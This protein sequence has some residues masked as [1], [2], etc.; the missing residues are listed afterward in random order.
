LETEKE[1]MKYNNPE[2]GNRM[3][4]LQKVIAFLRKIGVLK[5]GGEVRT[6]KSSKDEGYKPPDPLEN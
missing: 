1:Q 5:V 3:N 2:K 6:Y 4:F